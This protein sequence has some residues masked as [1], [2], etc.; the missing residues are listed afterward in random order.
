M[1]GRTP[2]GPN[3]SV[4]KKAAAR[5]QQ[6]RS[7]LAWHWWLVIGLVVAAAVAGIVIQS[8]RSETEKAKGDVVEPVRSLGPNGSEIEGQATAPVLVEE[9]A[10]F[11]CPACRAFHQV[12]GPTITKLVQDGSIR[13]AFHPFAFIGDE[14]TLAASAAT[15]AGDAGKFFP[16]Y[17]VLYDNQPQGENTGFFTKGRLVEFGRDAGITGADFTTFEKCV[18]ADKYHN[19]IVTLADKASERG[20]HQTPTVIVDGK[21][22]SGQ[23]LSTV[24]GFEQA[25]RTAA[26]AKQK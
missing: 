12:M 15:C 7:G 25:I 22:L 24:A 6:R 3:K 18:R 8:G 26:S 11:Q 10:D 2:G 13:F 4:A 20:I 9:Y 21:E 16:Y 23:S 5:A 19:W 1:A 17:D 14:S